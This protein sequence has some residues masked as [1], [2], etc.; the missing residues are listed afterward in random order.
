MKFD[1][2]LAEIREAARSEEAIADEAFK[3]ITE[4]VRRL[5]QKKGT[6]DLASLLEKVKEILD[7]KIQEQ[8]NAWAAE[9]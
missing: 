3:S 6:M 8:V 2:A 7:K 5:A 4:N 1:E 9:L